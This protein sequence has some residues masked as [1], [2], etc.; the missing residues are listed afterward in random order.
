MN[1]YQLLDLLNGMGSNIIQGQ[2]VFLS[3]LSAYLIV[4]YTV[5][6]KLTSYQI[7]FINLVFLIFMF[8]GVIAQ[9]SNMDS[10]Y[11]WMAQLSVL[12]GVDPYLKEVGDVTM[13]LFIGIRFVL[14]LGA[15]IFMWQVRHPRK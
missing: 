8:I 11:E 15:L 5:G 9:L 14:S 12:K 10:M 13:Y 2:T 3:I 4:A 7:A 6:E 1:E